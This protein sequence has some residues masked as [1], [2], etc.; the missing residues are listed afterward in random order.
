MRQN[1]GGTQRWRFGRVSQSWSRRTFPS[2]VTSSLW[3]T[4]APSSHPEHVTCIE[5]PFGT[6]ADGPFQHE[7]HGLEPCVRVRS[8]EGPIP[9]I[10]PIVHEQNER[11]CTPEGARRDDRHDGVTS[12]HETRRRTGPSFDVC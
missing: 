2:E 8:T 3:M 9:A 10:H 11:I 5:D 7:R 4:P 6:I 1:V 12:A